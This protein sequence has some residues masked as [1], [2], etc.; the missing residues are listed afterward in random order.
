MF[1]GTTPTGTHRSVTAAS[2][3]TALLA[4]FTFVVVGPILT[5]PPAKAL[6]SGTSPATGNWHNIDANT[7][8]VTRVIVDWGCADQ[9]LCPI[10]G[11][12]VY[13]AGSIRVFGRCHPTDCDWGVRTTYAEKDGWESARYN[14]S[15]ATKYVWIRPYVFSGR[16]YLRVWVFTDFTPADG[17][18][19]YTIDVWML[20]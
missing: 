13:P 5:A 12:C 15:W 8:S 7:N 11:P 1:G 17:R 6:C 16:T 2:I 10:G 19:D 18:K 9:G 14:Y 20:K 3:I 4:V